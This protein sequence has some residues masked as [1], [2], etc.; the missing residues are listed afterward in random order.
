METF[1]ASTQRK[2]DRCSLQNFWNQARVVTWWALKYFSEKKKWSLTSALIMRFVLVACLPSL[3][4][5]A[6]H[7]A[8][9]VVKGTN[10]V[11]ANF[12]WLINFDELHLYVGSVVEKKLFPVQ[13]GSVET[14]WH[15][16]LP[17]IINLTWKFLSTHFNSWF[18]QSEPKAQS[19]PFPIKAKFTRVCLYIYSRGN[20]M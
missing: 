16:K 2:S 14:W 4:D 19:K 12:R 7:E 15:S 6:W 5:M 9:I 1:F 10:I 17:R 3:P 20:A 18:P 8:I 11:A 13:C